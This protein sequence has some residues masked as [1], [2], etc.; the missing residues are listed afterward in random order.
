MSKKGL[1]ELITTV[2][3][4]GFTIVLAAVVMTWGGNFV[5]NLTEQQAE[6]TTT[7]TNCLQM[8]FDI[9]SV[10]IPIGATTT[11]VTFKV[12][13]NGDK[14]I[15]GFISLVQHSA[16][17]TSEGLD[18]D[19]KSTTKSGTTDDCAVEPYATITCVINPTTAKAID[20]ETATSPNVDSLKLIP[21]V[22]TNGCSVD[23]AK[24]ADIT[25]A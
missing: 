24:L 16:D 3:I 15:D 7:A 19:G 5:R 14:T 1:S 6:T 18:S 22:G 12:T 8:K 20:I 21:M 23:L 2:L 4:I 17:E 9:V 10:T 13:N 11:P 25:T